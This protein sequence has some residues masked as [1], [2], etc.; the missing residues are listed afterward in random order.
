MASESPGWVGVDLDGTLA[1]YDEWRGVNHIGAPVPAMVTLVK[2]MIAAG[3]DVRIFTARVAYE[4]EGSWAREVI[5]NWCAEHLGV[6]LPVTNVKDFGMIA[7][8]DDRCIQ[9]EQNTGRL[10]G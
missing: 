9:V 6:I 1:H 5:Q 4:P 2:A 7:L 8:Y 10:I 3:R